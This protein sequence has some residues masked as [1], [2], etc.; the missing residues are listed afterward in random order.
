MGIGTG[1]ET[2][3]I[4]LDLSTFFHLFETAAGIAPL[5][6]DANPPGDL[7]AMDAFVLAVSDDLSY[8]LQPIL[9]ERGGCR[10]ASVAVLSK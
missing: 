9:P 5:E 3:S 10:S 2:K 7:A 6:R 8:T 1:L 4:F